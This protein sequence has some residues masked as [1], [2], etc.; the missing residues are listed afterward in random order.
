MSVSL[1]IVDR[2]PVVHIPAPWHRQAVQFA[3]IA[4]RCFCLGRAV[5]VRADQREDPRLPEITIKTCHAREHVV[6]TVAG[7]I[8][9]ACSDQLL[10]ALVDAV[11]RTP[12]PRQLCCDLSGVTFI[13][14]TGIAALVAAKH[15]SENAGTEMMLAGA[16]GHVRRVLDL[17]GVQGLF[18]EFATVEGF[19]AAVG[20]AG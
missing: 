20:L 11:D 4:V 17:T 2:A 7:E 9:L 13:D 8:D 10:R 12:S 3:G 19:R 14:S 16:L 18:R 6:V 1:D 15:A 5:A